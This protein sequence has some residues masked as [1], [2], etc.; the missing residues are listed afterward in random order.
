MGSCYSDEIEEQKTNEIEEEQKTNKILPIKTRYIFGETIRPSASLA[1][2]RIVKAQSKTDIEKE[3]AIKIIDKH[4]PTTR[5][6][7]HRE[8]SIL[9]QLTPNINKPQKGIL[10]FVGHTED[11][12]SY[13]IIT[14][15]L[16]GGELLDRITSKDDEY[17]ITEIN[18]TNFVCDMLKIVKYCHDHGI[19]HRNLTPE[20][21][22]FANK[23]NDSDIIL[24][25]YGCALSVNDDDIIDDIV[26]TAH[27][28]A[29]EIATAVLENYKNQNLEVN[30]QVDS[31]KQLTGAILKASDIWSLG[32]IAYV[33]VT[34]TPPFDGCDDIQIL[35]NTCLKQIEFPEKIALT[36]QFK[37]FIQSMLIK[38]PTKRM[39]IEE[40]I[41]HPWVCGI[42]A[43][44]YRLSN[45]VIY[46]M[47]Q[48]SYQT[49]LKKE[50]R[51]AFITKEQDE[52]RILTHFT[53]LDADNDGCLNLQEL[54]FLL[55]DMGYARYEVHTQAVKIIKHSEK[56]NEG[57]VDFEEFKQVWYRNVLDKKERY[58]NAIF[59]L[60]LLFDYDGSGMFS[61]PDLTAT[62]FPEKCYSDFKDDDV[63]YDQDDQDD[64]LMQTIE[65]MTNEV[66]RNDDGCIDFE[67][68]KQGMRY[69]RWSFN[70]N[71]NRGNYGGL[72]GP[73][74]VK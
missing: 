63:D 71:E 45:R 3:V 27:Y 50:K 72:I 42:N 59:N 48:F 6:L 53:R 30:H 21:F 61:A 22:M 26:G 25:D 69:G 20:N 1:S 28:I 66:D 13:Y 64:G 37:D 14:P 57:L 47:R 70:S 33:M 15:F 67:E 54:T 65:M 41:S 17:R 39:S 56:Q 5:K 51:S 19:V 73:K 8:I 46:K 16:Y 68:F 38:D 2:C 29:P 12:G 9:K 10:P 62:L 44:N 40:G 43:N 49:K 58:I 35:E 24:I 60:L 23:R 55:L 74:V 52:I 18:V 34:G 36:E 31:P 4:G 7:Y 11:E 32:V